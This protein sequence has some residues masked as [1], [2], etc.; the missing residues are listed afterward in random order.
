MIRLGVDT[1]GTFTDFVC[2]VDGKLRVHKVLS[3]PAA[4]EQAILQ[5]ISDLG[6]NDALRQGG[7]L[8]VHG[9]TVAT[10][11]AL[12]GKGVKTAYIANKGLKDVL[13]IGR[14]ARA[15]LYN[16]TP[17]PKVHHFDEALLFE[18]S[19]RLDADGK[20]ISTFKPGELDRLKQAIDRINPEAVAINLLFSFLDAS[21]EKAIEARLGKSYFISRSSLVLPEYKEYERGITTWM[22]AWVGPIIHKYLAVLIDQVSPSALSVMQSSGLTIAAKLAGR[23]AVNML[24][25]G[26]AGGLTAAQSIGQA[27]Q[28]TR[29]I[30]FDMGGTSTDVSLLE[31]RFRLTNTGVVGPY[32]VAVPMAD[33]HTIGAGGGSIASIDQGGLLQ[34]GP[35]SAGASPGPACYGQGGTSPTVTDANLVLGM[36]GPAPELAGGLLLDRAAAEQ[37]FEP[38]AQVLNTTI[39]MV[40]QGVID[41]TNEHMSQALRLIS[42]HRGYDPRDFVLM[43]FGGG[44]GLHLCELADSLQMKRAIIPPHGGVLSALGMLA[45]R[46]GRALVQTYQLPLAQV[47]AAQ[48][49]VIFTK[50]KTQAQQELEKEQVSA[51]RQHQSLD[52]RYQ[53]QSASIN[54]GYQSLAQ[55]ERSFH[56]AHLQQ[57]GHQ[58]D[59]VVELVNCHLHIEADTVPFSLPEVSET[60]NQSAAHNIFDLNGSL[61]RIYQR[62]HLKVGEV[63][64]GPVLIVEPHATTLI[65]EG[66]FITVDKSGSLMLEKHGQ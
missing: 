18:V 57:F 10:N 37:A 50:M 23:R 5:G 21:Q 14:Q 19:A 15:E 43:C 36:L 66:W 30:T 41:L 3:T 26:P 64:S 35:A 56:Q 54:V 6:L 62:M 8:I 22:N 47:T 61:T 45:T 63:L 39:R 40:A 65:K 60:A 34:V 58:L 32:P 7:I 29:L 2:L 4:P 20:S 24:L 48:L 49:S 51:T 33:I 46:P 16:L 38:L 59:R 28:Q 27:L 53:G 42:V 11:A 52:L 9:T 44:G 12:E 1:G 55:A 13:R 31:E 25:S 17:Q